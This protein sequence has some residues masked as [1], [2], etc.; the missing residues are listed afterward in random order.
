M[1]DY[2]HRIDS[3]SLDIVKTPHFNS[4]NSAFAWSER[5]AS[6][7][8]VQRSLLRQIFRVMETFHRKAEVSFGAQGT[9]LVTH[10]DWKSETARIGGIFDP[11]VDCNV[12]N[13]RFL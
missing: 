9:A 5:Y 6:T 8:P 2:G 1:I 4:E 3:R 11:N 10:L 12:R 7:A 13:V